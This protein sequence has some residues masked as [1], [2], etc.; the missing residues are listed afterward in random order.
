MYNRDT[1]HYKMQCISVFIPGIR[2]FLTA[3]L[4]HFTNPT[5]QTDTLIFDTELHLCLVALAQPS[6][7]GPLH[8]LGPAA[9]V[10]ARAIWPSQVLGPTSLSGF[11]AFGPH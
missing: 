9:L 5:I 7:L 1:L 10:G 11:W 3:L 8:M 4:Y 2:M 6:P